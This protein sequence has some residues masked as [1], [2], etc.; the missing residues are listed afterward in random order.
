M[1]RL[2]RIKTPEMFQGKYKKKRYFEGWYY[3]ITDKKGRN[4]FAVIPGI[5]IGEW[6]SHAF[7]QVLH[8]NHKVSHFNFDISEFQ[9]NT[10]K[11][12]IMIG[13]NYFSK[14]RIRLNLV[15]EDF[16]LQG[17]LYF[18]DILEYSSTCL[19][20]GVMGPFLYHPWMECYMDIVNIQHKIVGHLKVS[21][22]KINYTDGIG[23][24][25][26][27]WGRSMPKSWVWVQSNHFGEDDVSLS[28]NIGKIPCMGGSFIG[29]VGL[30]RFRDRIFMF[31]TYSGARIR[32]LYTGDHKLYLTL[33]DCRF[34][35]DI[36][37]YYGEGGKILAPVDG[38]MDR[39][40]VESMNAVIKV[41]FSDRFGNVYY[42][43]LGTSGG[44]EV[45]E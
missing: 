30:F 15:G 22:K 18:W 3:K 12:E 24:L 25:E 20:P 32:T 36:I 16:S 35:L 17:D 11:F 27:N 43:G 26:K 9:F 2:H 45:T 21:G 29:F 38:R 10:K 4:S 28:I 41:R 31:T 34:R 8:Q 14:T 7:I 5:A 33:T 6:S 19:K 40:I 42:E 44:L 37:A 1:Y 13:D 23:Y 39:T